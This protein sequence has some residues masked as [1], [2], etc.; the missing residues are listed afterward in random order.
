LR[1]SAT[2]AFLLDAGAL[3][4]IVVREVE[5]ALAAKRHFPDALLAGER[6]GLPPPDFDLGNS[7][8][9][10]ARAK[11]RRVIFTTTTGAG[12]LVSCW[13]AHAIYMGSTVNATAVA[14]AALRHGRDLVLIPAGLMSDPRFNAQEDWAAAATIASAAK[15]LEPGLQ[16][17]EGAAASDHWLQ[18]IDREG[19]GPIFEA[20]PHAAKLRA[21]G[22]T[23]D[24][25]FCAR[26]DVTTIAP[27]VIGRSR[28]GVLLRHG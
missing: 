26:A 24:I 1:A 20:A 14:R 12:R 3:E 11:G 17:G 19:L 9:E 27:R 16:T 13:G 22:L 8:L 10:V 28:T 4:L 7:P 5:E 2:A 21:V 23:A 15:R 6:N 18:R 25:A